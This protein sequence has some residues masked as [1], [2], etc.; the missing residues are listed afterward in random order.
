MCMLLAVN[1]IDKYKNIPENLIKNKLYNLNPQI[2]GLPII[3]ISAKKKLVLD[4]IN[5]IREQYFYLE[6]R[7]GTGKLNTWLDL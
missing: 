6:K 7:I 4:S 1:K 2:K 5:T 3:F